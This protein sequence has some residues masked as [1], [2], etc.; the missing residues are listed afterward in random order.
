MGIDQ[1]PSRS[2]ARS[3]YWRIGLGF[4]VLLALMLA[5]QA[6]LFLWL[7]VETEGGVPERMGRDF[8][9][10]VATD[11]QSALVRDPALDLAAYA[12][13][14]L[15]ELHRPAFLALPDGRVIAP[16][17]VP[18]PEGVALPRRRG[19]PDRD[20]PRIP[21]PSPGGPGRDE[22]PQGPPPDGPRD[23]VGRDGPGRDGGMLPRSP[24]GPPP[25]FGRRRLAL[26]PVLVQG[27]MAGMVFVAPTVGWRRVA[28]VL[29]PWLALGIGVL[30]VGGTALA[31]LLV[32]RPAHVQLSALED[33]AR[34]FGAGELS[35]RAPAGGGDEIAAVAQAFNRMADDLTA[36]QAEIADADRSRRQL[37]A[38]VS[39]ELMTPL[40]AIRGYAD[41]LTLPQFGPPG[42]D[43]QR[44]VRIVQ[45]EVE[46]IERLVGDLLDLAR[47]DAGGVSFVRET[48]SI[49]ELFDRVVAR[50]E[51]TA[52]EK[53]VRIDVRLPDE[54]MSVAGDTRRLEQALQNLATNALRY[55]PA[56]G[57]LALSAEQDDR[58][59][60]LRVAD[61]G[62][63]IAPAHLPHIFDRF[64]KADPAR[65]ETGSGLGLSIVKAIVERHGGRVTAAS[66]PGHTVFEIDLPSRDQVADAT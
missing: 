48:V 57:V 33:A 24:G 44:Y 29:G 62:P 47:Y 49:A 55:A 41:T 7:A 56:G 23:G 6:A 31:A 1:G 28:E 9:E 65:A 30:L 36:R 40:T 32:F 37:L 52:R 19:G 51:H 18:V 20:R 13:K 63:G 10:L 43:G 22:P 26:A 8:A 35:A 54:E 34:R 27:R 17:G 38:D 5:V 42:A 46:R 15:A 53:Q 66:E 16:P 3:L 60:R 50:H 45:Q 12:E 4:F 11:F 59:T 14:R 21:S 58:R 61:S 64:Y 2:W 25:M 39:H